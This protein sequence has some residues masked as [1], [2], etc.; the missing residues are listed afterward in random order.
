MLFDEKAIEHSEFLL[1]FEML[2]REITSL[3]IGNFKKECVK[4]RFQ[5]SAYWSFKQVSKIFDKNLSREEVKVLNNLVKNKDLVIQKADKG[6]NI[7]IL[8]RSDHISKLS[9]TLKDTFKF[10]RVNIKKG[11]AFNHLIHMRKRI[12][13]PLKKLEDKGEISEKQKNALYLSRSKPGVLYGLAKIH[14]ALEDG[15]ASFRLTLSAIGR[16]TYKLAK[17]CDEL[18][19][20]LTNNEYTIKDS[21]S[22][23][24]EILE[25]DVLLFVASFDIKS[26]FINIPPNKNVKT[27]CT[28]NLQKSNTC[29]Q[30]N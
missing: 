9:K 16:T 1:P 12:I 20:P 13:C 18:L 27:L 17:F 14:K 30:F 8:Q 5:D 28:K 10:K 29:W 11:K 3:D 15:I 23:A 21:F 7:V 4:C 26:L 6:N 2:F 25:F 19:K 22:L 24:K